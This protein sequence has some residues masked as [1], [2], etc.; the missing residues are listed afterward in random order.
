LSAPHGTE[1]DGAGLPDRRKA[2][3]DTVT[4][5]SLG[6][7][8]VFALLLLA[9]VAGLGRVPVWVL[10]LLLLARLGVQFWSARRSPGQAR[11]RASGWV[12]DLALIG[13]LLY[14]GLGQK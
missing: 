9:Q 10:A 13:L 14:V 5:I 8:V 1:P 11:R 2:T 3:P 6:L 4:W 12:I 7:L